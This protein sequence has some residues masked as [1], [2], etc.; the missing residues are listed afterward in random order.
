MRKLL[1]PLALLFVSTALLAQAQQA[2]QISQEQK[3]V[4]TAYA[5]LRTAV[6]YYALY[7]YATNPHGDLFQRV[8]DD[9]M[10]FTLSDIRVGNANDILNEKYSSFA[11]KPSGG[12][13][14]N[15]GMV[16]QMGDKGTESIFAQAEWTSGQ[17]LSEDWEVPMSEVYRICKEQEGMTVSRYVALTVTLEFRREF[18]SYKALWLFGTNRYGKPHTLNIDTVMGI[19][20]GALHD[21]MGK[22]IYPSVILD[23]D[24]KDAP[25]VREWFQANTAQECGNAAREVCCDLK[26]LQCGVTNADLQ[27]S[28]TN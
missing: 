27:H 24:L 13:V 18:I 20:G 3:V 26:D 8:S 11:T 10:R 14:I 28:L 21:L 23:T 1:T 15:A 4:E 6:K 2:T 17:S 25:G 19:S 12:R 22:R 5:K 9:D 16:T 7:Q